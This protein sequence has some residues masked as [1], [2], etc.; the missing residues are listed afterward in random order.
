MS[1]FLMRNS[2]E[3]SYKKIQ[4]YN[5]GTKA[6]MQALQLRIKVTCHFYQVIVETKIAWLMTTR[7]TKRLRLVLAE[8]SVLQ[9]MKFSAILI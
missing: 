5:I 1:F 3:R 9:K 7:L 6:V 8:L 4:N 2:Y